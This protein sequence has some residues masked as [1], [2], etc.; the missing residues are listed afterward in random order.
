MKK[1]L[2]FLS[3]LTFNFAFSQDEI[4]IVMP[5]DDISI[6][7]ATAMPIVQKKTSPCG[8]FSTDL[9]NLLLEPTETISEKNLSEFI[10]EMDYECIT[11]TVQNNAGSY[12]LFIQKELLDEK[13]GHERYAVHKLTNDPSNELYVHYEYNNSHGEFKNVYM[14]YCL[15][16]NSVNAERS[17]FGGKKGSA[18]YSE[19]TEQVKLFK[20]DEITEDLN[21]CT[22]QM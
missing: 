3:F 21:S 12:D 9:R 2:L 16:I 8:E 18:R 7:T 11:V 15:Y 20:L 13:E 5:A 6:D 4:A 19:M 10:S 14:T 1:I 17:Y 22:L